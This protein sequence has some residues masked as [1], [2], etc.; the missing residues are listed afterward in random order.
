MNRNKLLL[1]IGLSLFTVS[2]LTLETSAEK[3]E[4]NGTVNFKEPEKPDP[5]KPFSLVKPGTYDEWITVPNS[6]GSI[7][8]DP[9]FGFAFVPNLEFGMVE[10]QTNNQ[11]KNVISTIPYQSYDIDKKNGFDPND[12]TRAIK[13][14][15]PFL[16]IVN[17]RGTDEEYR[18]SVVASKFKSKEAGAPVHEL[19]NTR[20]EIKDFSTR[21]NQ[22]DSGTPNTDAISILQ[23]PIGSSTTNDGYISLLP[24]DSTE[25]MWTKKGS[26]KA[27]DGS[28]SSLVF[29]KEYSPDKVYPKEL[30]VKDDA[31]TSFDSVRLYIPSKDVP[32]ANKRY[33]ATLVWNLENVD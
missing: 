25:L 23:T 12:Q 26:G 33:E 6:S 24:N 19:E 3:I 9:L 21:N 2:A 1:T 30:N 31:S 27:T 18:V 22:L 28:A 10:V 5:N 11:Y 17:L 13:Y 32:K 20:I 4:T 8:T 7:S 16:Q 15:P 29:A 14:L